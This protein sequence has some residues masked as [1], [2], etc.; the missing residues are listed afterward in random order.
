MKLTKYV[1]LVVMGPL[2]AAVSEAA[3]AH[4]TGVETPFSITRWIKDAARGLR[5]AA[6]LAAFEWT[7]AAGLW[8]LG[9]MVPV[10]SPVTLPL[11]WL[12]GAW[13]YGASVMDCVWEREGK[14]ASGVVASVKRA[15]VVLSVGVPLP[16]DVRAG[17]GV[18]GGAVDGRDGSDHGRMRALKGSG[19]QPATV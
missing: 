9:L 4:M 15:D 16:F 10:L 1:V 7:L 6:L 17:F 19:S 5:S 3:E 14:G 18:D 8:A 12:L 2:F 11:A 13:A